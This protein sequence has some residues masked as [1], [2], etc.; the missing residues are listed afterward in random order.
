MA[1][2]IPYWAID[3]FFAGLDM[4]V[5]ANLNAYGTCA[6]I[7]SVCRR[8]MASRIARPTECQNICNCSATPGRATTEA[9]PGNRQGG[10]IAL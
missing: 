7:A 9:P 10:I 5:L 8:L 2:L 3:T 4:Q 6:G 1:L